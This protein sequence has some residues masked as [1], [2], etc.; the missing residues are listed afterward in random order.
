MAFTPLPT[1]HSRDEQ[2][3]RVFRHASAYLADC[4]T[5]LGA[6]PPPGSNGGR[7]TFTIALVLACVVDGLATEVSP[8]QPTDDQSVRMR[9]LVLRMD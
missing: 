4:Y 2:I 8:I 7:C 6:I 5:M 1:A 9:E 3:R